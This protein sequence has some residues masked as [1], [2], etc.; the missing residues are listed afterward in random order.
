MVIGVHPDD[1]D[2]ICGGTTVQLVERGFKVKF[3]SITD[4]R[5]GHHRLSP[6]ETARTRRVETAEAAKRFG[7]DGYDKSDR[8]ISPVINSADFTLNFA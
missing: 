8:L 4:G 1:A 5:M 3:V 2:I 7:F 6:D